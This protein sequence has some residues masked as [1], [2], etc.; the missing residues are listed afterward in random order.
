MDERIY[1]PEIEIAA[2][3]HVLRH[4]EDYAAMADVI[5]PESFGWHAFGWVWEAM[6]TLHAEGLHIDALTVGDALERSG[7]LGE[8]QLPDNKTF[9]DR[10]ALGQL[11][12]TPTTKGGGLTYASHVADYAAL[13]MLDEWT[14]TAH[15]HAHGG[16]TAAAI[17]S[18]LTTKLSTL[19]L[20]SMAAQRTN[21]METLTVRAKGETAAAVGGVR[22]LNTGLVDL[23]RTLRIRRKEFIVIAGRPGQGKSSLLDTILVNAAKDG[24]HG[25]LFSCEMGD[26]QVTQRMIAQ[27]SGLD[28]EK[29]QD[30][31]GAGRMGYL[32]CR[33]RQVGRTP[34]NHLRQVGHSG[35]PSPGGDAQ[36][37]P[38]FRRG[39]LRATHAPGREV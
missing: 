26:T 13:R 21:G 27:L 35:K 38:R 9:T 30:G 12:D 32:L 3:A 2:L 20:P 4:P 29:I 36:D 16:R 37:P 7:R 10:A 24:K 14:T 31:A 11:R 25:L 1:N 19:S 6:G 17:V 34:D 8:F 39:R 15:G 23:D 28:G 5:R 22:D 18:D 33:V